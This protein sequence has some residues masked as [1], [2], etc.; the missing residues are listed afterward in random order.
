MTLILVA[1]SKDTFYMVADTRTCN[2]ASGSATDHTKKVFYSRKH[3]IG[4]CISGDADLSDPQN[5]HDPSKSICVNYLMEEFFKAIDEKEESVVQSE[6]IEH[7]IQYLHQLICRFIRTKFSADYA[8]VFDTKVS[9]L[10]AAF[11]NAETVIASYDGPDDQP[12]HWAEFHF[13][14]EYSTKLC[15]FSNYQKQLSDYAAAFVARA[16]AQGWPFQG[17]SELEKQNYL[18]SVRQPRFRQAVLDNVLLEVR[19]VVLKEYPGNVGDYFEFVQIGHKAE[20]FKNLK[21]VV[22][23]NASASALAIVQQGEY[24]PE[25]KF[26]RTGHELTQSMTPEVFPVSSAAAKP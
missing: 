9:I 26:F 19:D 3:K 24:F 1:A 10:L 14:S 11:I 13:D 5:P 20:D 4:V 7:G 18:F 21:L 15:A 6:L 8:A 25:Y 22:K 12:K 23:P 17:P 16:I 2:I